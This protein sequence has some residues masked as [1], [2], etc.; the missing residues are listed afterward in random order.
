MP[1]VQHLVGGPVTARANLPTLRCL[2]RIFHGIVGV[3][4]KACGIGLSECMFGV[5]IHVVLLTEA[6]VYFLYGLPTTSTYIR[7]NKA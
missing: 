1:V 5:R 2:Y 3:C 4:V 7:P 6:H